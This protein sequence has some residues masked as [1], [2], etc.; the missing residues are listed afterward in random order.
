MPVYNG[1]DLAVEA[2]ESVLAQTFGDFELIVSDNCSTDDTEARMRA[3]AERDK[4][5]RYVRHDRNLGAIP[6]FNGCVP[7]ARGRYFKWQAADDLIEPD[8]LAETVAALEA[9]PDSVLAHSQVRVIDGQGA[10]LAESP[11]PFRQWDSVDVVARWRSALRDLFCY[12]I[13]GLMKTDVLRRTSL[14]ASFRGGDKTLLAEMSL[15]G[16]FLRVDRPL[17]GRRIHEQ[18]SGAQDGQGKQSHAGKRSRVPYRMQAF[19]HYWRVIAQH[20]MSARQKARCRVEVLRLMG[21]YHRWY[22]LLVPGPSNYLGIRG[23]GKP[24]AGCAG[25]GGMLVRIMEDQQRRRAQLPQHR[26]PQT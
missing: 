23:R 22:K 9:S 18:M 11:N 24:D 8:Y 19:R 15:R 14:H 26:S 13:Y 21:A 17:F 16:R 1:G 10:V 12:E 3:L 25:E 7:L 2:A 20:P 6:N 4:R 5:V